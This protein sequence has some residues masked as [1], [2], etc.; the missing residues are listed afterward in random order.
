MLEAERILHEMDIPYHLI[1]LTERAVTAADVAQHSKGN[2]KVDEICKTIIMRDDSGNC[3]AFLL[4][5]TN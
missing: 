1:E 3:Y 2:I 5:G 4:I